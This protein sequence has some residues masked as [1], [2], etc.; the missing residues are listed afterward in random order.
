VQLNVQLPTADSSR[1]SRPRCSRESGDTWRRDD[2]D[3]SN[4]DQLR[5]VG[6][7]APIAIIGAAVAGAGTALAAVI[8]AGAVGASML[9]AAGLRRLRLRR[10]EAWLARLPFPVIGYV[11]VLA[12]N[13]TVTA[14]SARITL[15]AIEP[16]D[17]N[18]VLDLLGHLESVDPDVAIDGTTIAIDV[19]RTGSVQRFL[20][21]LIERVA[22]ALRGTGG[23]ARSDRR[24]DCGAAD[25][26]RAV[27]V[28]AGTEVT[29]RNMRTGTTE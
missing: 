7:V 11:Q 1:R 9:G 10:E 21:A 24:N 23:Q 20:R 14:I 12:Q 8:G 5:V 17:R 19:L 27:P 13:R 15:A 2:A 4:A 18:R 22:L 6:A 28:T 25:A 16:D 3:A 29:T 26:L